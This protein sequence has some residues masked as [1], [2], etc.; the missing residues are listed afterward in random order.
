MAEIIN[1]NEGKRRMLENQIS[2]FNRQIQK[3]M[4][5][6]AD[7]NRVVANPALDVY[8]RTGVN[9]EIEKLAGQKADLIELRNKAKQNLDALSGTNNRPGRF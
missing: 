3:L 6:I 2:G 5:Q 9:Y 7:L 1:F 4:N 8:E